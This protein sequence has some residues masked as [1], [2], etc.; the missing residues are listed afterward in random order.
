M[1]NDHG[2]CRK[3]GDGGYGEHDAVGSSYS[4]SFLRSPAEGR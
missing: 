4:S 3:Q 1:A 2:T